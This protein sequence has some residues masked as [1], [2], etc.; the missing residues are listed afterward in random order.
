MSAYALSLLVLS[1]ILLSAMVVVL[2][3][4]GAG[5]RAA[6]LVAHGL[7]VVA[8]LA[9]LAAYDGG[10]GVLQFVERRAWVPSLGVEYHLGVDGLGLVGVLLATVVPLM[11]VVASREVAAGRER[12]YYGL[13]LALESGLLGT[14]TALNFFHW[15]LFWE[16]S[17]VPAYLLVRI[18]GGA[19]AAPA[20]FQFFVYT[21]VGSVG[22]LL[23]FLAL[24]AAGGSFDFR[25]LAELGRSGQ[26]GGALSAQIPWGGERAGE[27]LVWLVFVGIVLGF[28]VKIPVWPFHTWLPDTYAEAPTP[29]TMLLTGVMSKM[30]VYGLLRIAWPIFPEQF[31]A[32]QWVLVPLAV[33]TVVMPA[34]AAFAQHDLKRVLAYSS[35][36]HLGYCVLGLVS[37]PAGVALGPLVQGAAA[38][39]MNGVI[40]QMLNHGLTAAALFGFVL[41]LE[42]RTGGGRDLRELGGLGQVA[43][44]LCGLMSVSIFA[45]V[46]LP[47]LNG[48]ISEFLIFK[49]VFAVAPV[50]GAVSLLGLLASAVFLLTVIQRVFHGPLAPGWRGLEDLDTRERL[51]FAVPTLLMLVLG[52]FPGVVLRWIDPTVMGFLGG[53]AVWR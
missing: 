14:F 53:E 22:L 8:S 9:L 41:V 43:P 27:V 4:R 50:A 35:V 2:P 51:L 21:M 36:N 34:V 12:L 44:V 24:R 15:F 13:V 29:V 49:G 37:L 33:A 3:V 47:G 46:G 32:A 26:L 40:L 18:F 42:R 48:F 52:I 25:E 39:A 30:G 17:L 11:A 19:R 7:L 23:G 5:V 10:A 38:P 45:S 1:P 31:R 16:L 6:A 20:A 28:A